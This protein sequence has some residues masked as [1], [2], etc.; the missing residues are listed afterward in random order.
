M[1]KPRYEEVSNEAEALLKKASNLAERM[2][3]IEKYDAVKSGAKTCP[4]GSGKPQA[5]C[6]PDMKKASPDYIETF[7]TKPQ[8]V[9]FVT[10]SGGQTKSAGYSTN[11][12]LMDVEDVANKGANSSAFS[13]DALA[14]KMNAHQNTGQD[15][16]VSS[17]NKQPDRD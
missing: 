13:F 1:M 9:S 5:D 7:S 15:H 17:D 2:A 4:C 10:E 12:H 6:C 11:G 8:D 14:D 16:V 3:A